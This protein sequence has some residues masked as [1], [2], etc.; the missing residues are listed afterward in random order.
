MGPECSP[1]LSKSDLALLLKVLAGLVGSSK[2]G[3]VMGTFKCLFT[4]EFSVV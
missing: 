3:Q 4:T 2:S 1:V